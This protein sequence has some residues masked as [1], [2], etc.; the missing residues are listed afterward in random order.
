MKRIHRRSDCLLDHME[1]KHPCGQICC[2][3][4]ASSGLLSSKLSSGFYLNHPDWQDK[5]SSVNSRHRLPKAQDCTCSSGDRTFIQQ[6]ERR[7]QFGSRI[8]TFLDF[9]WVELSI[10]FNDQIDFIGIFI[11]VIMK[12]TFQLGTVLVKQEPS[13][14]GSK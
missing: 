12:Q 9:Q 10:A 11:P 7:Y 3:P 14:T 2:I 4:S 6:F 13:P 5:C 1:I 8:G